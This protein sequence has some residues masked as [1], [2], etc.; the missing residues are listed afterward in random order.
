M[1]EQP[2]AL[3]RGIFGYRRTA[4]NQLISDRD[5]ML[6]QAEGRVRASETKV[7]RLESDVAALRQANAELG[8][9]VG[10]LRADLDRAIEA[11]ATRDDTVAEL[12][13]RFVND[14]L[15]TVL[16]AAEE[17]ATRIVERATEVTRRQM[18]DS[19]RMWREA[20]AQV[21]AFSAWRDQIDPILRGAT[22]TIED[23]RGRIGD[24]PE[25]IRRALA[26][27]ANAIASLEGELADAAAATMMPLPLSVTTLD[28]TDDA[29]AP[30]APGL[31]GGDAT[32][33]EAGAGL[34]LTAIGPDAEGP[35]DA[36]RNGQASGRRRG[37][38][39]LDVAVLQE[40][41]AAAAGAGPEADE[42][43]TPTDTS[44]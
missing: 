15:A 11:M 13:S 31:A 32:D 10:R 12:T 25:Q 5:I 20:E 24:V 1:S 38:S 22:A 43:S 8:E 33:P 44:D 34:D 7:A 27:L 23:V 37:R 21:G 19:E 26:P 40:A 36:P 6:R 35:E 29:P 30:D 14:E 39:G 28:L 4:V 2:P 41:P 17:S 9:E 16:R 42:A 18:A 3:E